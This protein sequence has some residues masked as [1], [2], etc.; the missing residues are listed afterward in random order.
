MEISTQPL[1]LDL[2]V[3]DESIDGSVE[4]R[5]ALPV[6]TVAERVRTRG[7]RR[8]WL[9]GR[10][11][12]QWIGLWRD[13]YIRSQGPWFGQ[14]LEFADAVHGRPL[15]PASLATLGTGR[16]VPEG[17]SLVHANPVERHRSRDEEVFQP[18]S[19]QLF[20]RRCPLIL[21]HEVARQ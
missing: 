18:V 3:P 4:N 19:L 17:V 21:V 16:A 10:A 5:V 11:V 9:L 13:T 15:R 20:D 8:H 12:Q 14:V 2:L 7:H 6:P 1:R